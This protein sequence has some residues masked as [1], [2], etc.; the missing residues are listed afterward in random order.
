M[1]QQKKQ[2]GRSLIGIITSTAL[3]CI[4]SELTIPILRELLHDLSI[5]MAVDLTQQLSPTRLKEYILG[6]HPSQMGRELQ[7]LFLSSTTDALDNIL[8]LY[9]E[10][11]SDRHD[12]RR[13]KRAIRTLVKQLSHKQQHQLLDDLENKE[14]AMRFTCP[15]TEGETALEAYLSQQLQTSSDLPKGLKQMI[16]QHLSPQVQL[17]FGHNLGQGHHREAWISY[18][19]TL[20][21]EIYH[22][23]AEGQPPLA[24]APIE[25]HIPELEGRLGKVL[26]RRLRGIEEREDKLI[27]LS[28]E[29]HLSVRQLLQQNQSHRR[30]IRTMMLGLYLLV[31]ALAGTLSYWA[32]D[33]RQASFDLCIQIHGWLGRDHHLIQG[34]A[35]LRVELGEE[36]RVL[37]IDR[38]GRVFLSHLPASLAGKSI[39]VHISQPEGMPY[40]SLQESMLLDP[41]RYIHYLE[42]SIVGLDRLDGLVRNALT[43][44]EIVGAEVYMAGERIHTDRHGRFTLFI[45]KQR[46][47]LKQ[48][49]SVSKTGFE[50]YTRSI[51]MVG[52]DPTTIFLEP[53]HTTG[54]QAQD[55]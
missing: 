54:Q 2:I 14:I 15:E 55:L 7:R 48:Q 36:I 10:T 34:E 20:L 24:S 18:E 49:I 31:L 5:G 30:Q 9:L 40:Y 17:C 45:S 50:R 16:T 26:A 12:R 29:T 21:E 3:A 39:S 1:R 35:S 19:R 4:T 41:K 51:P 44:D 47:A 22:R 33:R 8:T 52:I 6:A 37:D 13:A 32:Y 42:A 53:K 11:T 25:L 46:Q 38:H 28:S 27:H 43:G 23:L